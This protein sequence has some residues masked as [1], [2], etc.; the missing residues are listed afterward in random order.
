MWRF[1]GSFNDA[2][3]TYN[4]TPSANPPIFVNGYVGQA[5][6]FTASAQQAIYTPFIPI[7]EISFTI[8]A[9]INPSGFPNPTD[10]SI[11]GLCPSQRADYCLHVNIRNGKLYFGFYYNDLA[12]ATTITTGRW[13]HTA[14]VFDVGAMTLTIYL[15]GVMDGKTTVTSALLVSSGIFTIG[16]N[17]GVALPQNFFQ[18]ISSDSLSD[19]TVLQQYFM[20]ILGL[21]RPSLGELPSEVF[22]RDTRDRHSRCSVQVR[23]ARSLG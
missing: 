21:H 14:F 22:L 6:S 8:E 15:N 13:I 16:T 7:H 20:N 1:E 4:G 5:A 17:Q 10:A 23:L 11:V 19:C 2:T 3:N 12:G 9:W 18:V